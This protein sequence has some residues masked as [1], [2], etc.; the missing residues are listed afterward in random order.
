MEK[1]LFRWHRRE[2]VPF[3]QEAM[4]F[5]PFVLLQLFPCKVFAGIFSCSQLSNLKHIVRCTHKHSQVVFLFLIL[6]SV[7]ADACDK[8]RQHETPLVESR[9]FQ[10]IQ[11][12]QA[13]EFLFA[14]R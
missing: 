8:Q 4:N 10:D 11:Q 7:A 12:H 3:S 1:N 9:C 14:K 5:S 2:G 6:S 13:F